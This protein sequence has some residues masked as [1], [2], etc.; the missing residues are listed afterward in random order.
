MN[1]HTK[2]GETGTAEVT[3]IQKITN[4]REYIDS[5]FRGLFRDVYNII[6]IAFS[7]NKE[8]GEKVKELTGK[9]ISILNQNVMESMD[10]LYSKD[11]QQTLPPVGI[12]VA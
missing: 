12:R 9:R 1:T 10:S 11:F 6:E 8:I 4:V 7:E 3:D 5:E 2:I